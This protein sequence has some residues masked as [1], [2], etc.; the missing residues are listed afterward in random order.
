MQRCSCPLPW[1]VSTPT[2]RHVVSRAILIAVLLAGPFT[3]PPAVSFAAA[4]PGHE[5]IVNGDF[6]ALKQG[7]DLR[8]DDK[9]QDWYESRK[10]TKDGQALLKLS[11]KAIGGNASKKA[12]IKGDLQWNTYLSQRFAEPQTVFLHVQYDIYVKEILPEH[13]RSAFFFLGTIKDKK[14]GP[15]STGSERFVFLGFENA[16]QAGKINLFAR[17]GESGWAE[18]TIVARDLDL[19]RWYT[20]G[21]RANVPEGIYEVK[22]DGVTDWFEVEAC[23]AKGRTPEKLTHLSFASW[24]DG[25]GTFYVD[26]VRA[27]DR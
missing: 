3:L 13:N 5:I 18:R 25:S 16:E 21:V 26:N 27:S 2:T 24:N 1:T 15:N 23:F 22:V 14:N 4:A 19:G 20:I 9:G 7:A 11:T 17:E 8:R 10:D 12:M 6:E